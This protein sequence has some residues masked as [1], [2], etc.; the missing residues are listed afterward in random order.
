MIT[1]IAF[2]QFIA[3]V[4][5]LYHIEKVMYKMI[6]YEYEHSRFW[7]IFGLIILNSLSIH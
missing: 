7:S 1:N 4:S 3:K 2:I 5:I 6:T